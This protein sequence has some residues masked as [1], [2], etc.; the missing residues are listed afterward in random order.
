LRL[1]ET[2]KVSIDD[3]IA[4]TKTLIQRGLVN[5]PSSQASFRIIKPPTS[6]T[7][8]GEFTLNIETF[9][10]PRIENVEQLFSASKIIKID[11]DTSKDTSNISGELQSNLPD[12]LQLP[13]ITSLTRGTTKQKQKLKQLSFQQQMPKLKQAQ[14]QPQAQSLLQLQ[15]QKTRQDLR[16]QSVYSF[17]KFKQPKPKK[18]KLPIPIPLFFKTPSFKKQPSPSFKVLGRRFGKFKV[19]GIAKTERGAFQIGKRFAG[20]TL[21]VSFK[22]PK[23]KTLKLPGFRTKKEDGGI[24]FIEPR[25]KRLKKRGQE[26]LEIQQFKSLK[27]GLRL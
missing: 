4:V 21:G 2:G 1:G 12:T 16:Q 5:P 11:T 10:A 26:V 6:T 23:S 19:I 25:G 22:I 7:P 14:F 8:T 20:T 17:P 9:N 13:T 27:G 3:L 24:I 15:K 18:P